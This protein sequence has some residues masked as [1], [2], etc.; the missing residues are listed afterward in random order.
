MGLYSSKEAS[1]YRIAIIF[2]YPILITLSTRASKSN[3][4]IRIIRISI[5]A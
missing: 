5:R 2:I 3:S 4:L 1:L